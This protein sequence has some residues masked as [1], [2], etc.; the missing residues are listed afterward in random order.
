M[1]QYML[2]LLNKIIAVFSSLSSV[3][4]EDS[5]TGKQIARS[6]ILFK[7]SNTKFTNFFFKDTGLSE[8]A[9][10]VSNETDLVL[11]I[12]ADTTGKGIFYIALSYA[13]AKTSN[14]YV[15]HPNAYYIDSEL[16]KYATLKLRKYDKAWKSLALALSKQGLSPKQYSEVTHEIYDL[17]GLRYAH[18]NIEEVDIS[19]LLRNTPSGFKDRFREIVGEEDIDTLRLSD[20]GYLI[21]ISY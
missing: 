21:G 4:F 17:H 10:G 2:D 19:P 8:V 14:G 20:C 5:V 1:D 3:K 6:L 11:Q 7:N 18:C 16:E 9:C 13:N 15:V 12:T